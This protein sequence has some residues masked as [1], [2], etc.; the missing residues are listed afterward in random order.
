MMHAPALLIEQQKVE[1][2][3]NDGQINHSEGRKK[4]GGRSGNAEIG[5][6]NERRHCFVVE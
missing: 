3:T 4:Y 1:H 2:Q 5:H 6:G